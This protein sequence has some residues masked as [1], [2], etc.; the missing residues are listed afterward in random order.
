MFAKKS[1]YEALLAQYSHQGALIELLKQFRPYLE[2]V[3]SMRRPL[4][5]LICI[6]LPLI[7]QRV[8]TARADGQRQSHSEV[9][10]LPCDLGILMCDPEW[11]IKTGVEICVFI[12]RPQ[13]D[14]SDLL[15]RWRQ[16]QILLSDSYEWVMPRRYRHVMSDG[17]D[18]VLPL[19]LG[20]AETPERVVWG[21]RGAALPYV[22]QQPEEGLLMADEL[23]LE[24]DDK[25]GIG[26]KDGAAIAPSPPANESLT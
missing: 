25:E 21:L 5:S 22:Q 17:A 2:L 10:E 23:L 14:F 26:Q 11:K 12:C 18:E 4:E 19:F 1:H 20:G 3:P 8:E 15:R 6:P 9:R 24:S 16:T 7:I 13:E